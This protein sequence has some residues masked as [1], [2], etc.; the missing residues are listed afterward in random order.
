M[1]KIATA[2]FGFGAGAFFLRASQVTPKAPT[3]GVW[4][5]IAVVLL[6]LA[7]V[8]VVRE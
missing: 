5:I 1:N 6:T 2:L 3:F 4:L 8:S 7:F